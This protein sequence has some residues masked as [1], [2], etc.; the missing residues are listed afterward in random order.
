MK[1]K[2]LA[3]LVAL[4]LTLCLL[5]SIPAAATSWGAAGQTASEVSAPALYAGDAVIL[6]GST[7]RHR[8]LCGRPGRPVSD[9][10]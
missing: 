1:R 8:R 5:L 6:T 10:L 4:A 2:A 9:R 3:R 7:G